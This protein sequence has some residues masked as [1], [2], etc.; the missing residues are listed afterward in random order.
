MFLALKQLLGNSDEYKYLDSS[1]RIG[2]RH[3]ASGTFVRISSGSG[4]GALGLGNNRV[5]ILDEPAALTGTKG[6]QL[7]DALVTSL[8]KSDC[9]VVMTGTRAPAG[10]HH[11]WPR[12]LDDPPE[13]WYVDVVEADPEKWNQWREVQRANP[14]TRRSER[15]RK[16]LRAELKQ[17]RRS[18]VSREQFLKYRLNISDSADEHSLMTLVEWK[19][20]LKREPGVPDGQTI[21]GLDLG[22]SRSWS[23]ATAIHG[24]G[25]VESLAIT[26]GSIEDAERRDQ[27][28]RGT[29]A[30]LCKEGSLLVDPDGRRVPD[31]TPLAEWIDE[32]QPLIVCGDLFR[33]DEMRDLLDGRHIYETRRTRWSESTFDLDAFLAL[34][35]DQGMS[36]S[37]DCRKLLSVALSGSRVKPDDAGNVRLVKR[38]RT[39]SRTDPV[40]ALVCAAG[41]RKR[42]LKD[43]PEPTW[44]FSPAS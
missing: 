4:T 17:A 43:V 7:Y 34:A 21:I 40:A 6:L 44:S 26:G 1:Q 12:L 9:Q 14:W 3:R 8:G 23:S 37:P 22:G 31:L 13:D 24:S 36:V 33:E 42:H 16:R 29:Y 11:F 19:S 20:I 41:A 38:H 32:R 27:V 5:L 10:P 25:L 39:A 15:F 28:A 30:T 35:H 18:E 2:V